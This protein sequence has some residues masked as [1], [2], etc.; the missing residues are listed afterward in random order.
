MGPQHHAI[1]NRVAEVGGDLGS[2]AHSQSDQVRIR[3]LSVRQDSLGGISEVNHEFGS[4]A[5]V[6][7][8]AKGLLHFLAQ[9]FGQAFGIGIRCDLNGQDMQQGQ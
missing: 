4:T 6:D 2:P 8:R 9:R 7:V 5:G 1:R 3:V